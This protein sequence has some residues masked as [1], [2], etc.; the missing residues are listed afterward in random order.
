ML[1]RLQAAPNTRTLYLLGIPTARVPDDT[2]IASYKSRNKVRAL[3]TL[4]TLMS[5]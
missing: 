1:E 5:R 2:H 4:M 3:R